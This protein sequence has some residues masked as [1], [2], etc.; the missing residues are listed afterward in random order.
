[1][2]R[3]IQ[4][5]GVEVDGLRYYGDALKD[6]RN[7]ESPYGGR[8]DGAWPIRVN[9]D[10]VRYVYF[11]DPDDWLAPAGV[12]ARPDAWAPR[13]APKPP[14]TPA[15]RGQ[16]EPVARQGKA[17]AALLARWNQGMVSGRR[18]RRMARGWPPSALR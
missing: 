7:A 12:G 13:S 16:G 4:H 8:L 1:M 5:Y 2:P 11:Q 9:P 18:E 17:L 3:T 10:D 6:H 14:G 15:A